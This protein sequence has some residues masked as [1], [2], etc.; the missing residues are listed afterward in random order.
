MQRRAYVRSEHAARVDFRRCIA[1]DDRCGS[2]SVHGRRL[3][4]PF[5]LGNYMGYG[6]LGADNVDAVGMGHEETERDR[7]Q[8]NKRP[9]FDGEPTR[10]EA[11]LLRKAYARLDKY[12]AEQ[13]KRER[14]S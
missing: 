7:R 2:L 9:P 10:E 8:V 6:I 13:R 11:K 5:S 3:G 14:G 12:L 1:R 4:E